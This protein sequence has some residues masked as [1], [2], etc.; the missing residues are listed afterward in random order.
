MNEYLKILTPLNSSKL[1][2]FLGIFWE[3][4]IFWIQILSFELEQFETGRY[5]NRS[6]PV[7]PV[8]A[9]S[10]PVSVGKKNPGLHTPVSA[11][12]NATRG[13]LKQKCFHDRASRNAYDLA[14]FRAKSCVKLFS[15]SFISSCSR[16]FIINRCHFG[17]IIFFPFFL[18]W[19]LD[20]PH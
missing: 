6:G 1:K 12:D 16:Y 20:S 5:R 3:F 10:G 9:V 11:A 13:F 19:S 7:T 18:V 4:F 15:C 17:S 8:T 14:R 2:V